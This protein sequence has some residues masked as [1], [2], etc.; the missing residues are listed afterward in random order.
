MAEFEGKTV[1]VTGAA[2]GIGQAIVMRFAGEGARVI[3]VD[4]NEEWLADL[5]DRARK[6]GYGI[7]PLA[8]DCSSYAAVSAAANTIAER[9]GPVDILINN[10]GQSV[11]EKS[12]EFTYSDPAVWDY[13]IDTNLRP[14]MN[15]TRVL[16]PQMRERG[17]GKIVNVASESAIYGDLKLVDYAAAKGGVLGFTRGIA[18]ELAPYG[19]NVNAVSPGVTRTRAI[20]AVPKDVVD[21]AIAQ[22]PR[23]KICEPEDMAAVIRFLASHDAIGVVGQNIIVSGG[24][25]MQ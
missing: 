1:V 8:V 14:T 22:I 12:A 13:L 18:R 2:G 5:V 7:E 19:I 9:F 17:S 16:A 6:L 24:R 20:E 11:R 25:T 4:K 23:G 15:W 10:C 21:A 3:A